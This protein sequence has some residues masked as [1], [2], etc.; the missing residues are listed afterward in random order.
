MF[1]INTRLRKD[2]HKCH[3]EHL[4]TKTNLRRRNLTHGFVLRQGEAQ[5]WYLLVELMRV[6]W[7]YEIIYYET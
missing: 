2:T 6:R 1:N 7:Q 4:V 3:A 5:G